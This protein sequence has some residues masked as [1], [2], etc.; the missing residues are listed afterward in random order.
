[1]PAFKKGD[2]LE[3]NN[4]RPI[5]L[6]SNLSKMIEKLMHKRLYCFLEQ[7]EA[8]HNLQYGFRNKHST[9]H[10]IIDITEKIR[11]ALNEGLIACGVFI[12][13]QKAFDTV[14]HTILLDKLRYYGVRGIT[15]KWFESFLTNRY[16][17]TTI[18]EKS[19]EKIK[20]TYGVP[21]GSVLGPLLF[22]IY[23]NDLHNSI[24][25]STVHH[26]ADDTNLLLTH[27]SPKMINKLINYDLI[28]LCT[29]LRANRISL[30]AKKD[31]NSFLYTKHKE[32]Y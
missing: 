17:Y 18:K 2:I 31:R 6:L 30:N 23:I 12:D 22:L 8:L 10:A 32:Y 9:N 28:R 25:H 1:M 13:L 27:K 5:S 14:K 21:Q 16:Q 3:C 20:S 26:F 29:W 7:H 15:N 19:S 24:T 11:E 4:Y